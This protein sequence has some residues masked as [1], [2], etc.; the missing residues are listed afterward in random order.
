MQERNKMSNTTRQLVLDGLMTFASHGATSDIN[1]ISPSARLRDDLAL[2]S[3]KLLMVISYVSEQMDLD[4]SEFSDVD[5]HGMEQVAD[6]VNIFEEV[7]R[8]IVSG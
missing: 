2:D 7:S 8:A 4:L 5:F 3:L 6:L 1:R